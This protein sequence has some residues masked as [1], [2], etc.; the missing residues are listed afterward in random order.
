MEIYDQAQFKLARLE[1][2]NYLRWIDWM[3]RFNRLYF[4][5]ERSANEEVKS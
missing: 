5:D 1:I 2:M 3:N 4:D